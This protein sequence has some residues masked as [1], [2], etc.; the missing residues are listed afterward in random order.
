M[1]AAM[2]GDNLP[3]DQLLEQLLQ[4]MQA[5]ES[6]IVR[7]ASLQWIVSLR[8]KDPK[9][10]MR[11]STFQRLLA[12]LFDVLRHSEDEVVVAALRILAQILDGR[13]VADDD[14]LDEDQLDLYQAVIRRV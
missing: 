13:S 3:I 9:L 4:S 7:T 5:K 11:R 1:D 10:M 8:A 2:Q 6:V 12:P 14:S